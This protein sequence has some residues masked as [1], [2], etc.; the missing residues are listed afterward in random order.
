MNITQ[1]TWIPN[2]PLPML[3]PKCSAS[4]NIPP[5]HKQP[6]QIQRKKSQTKKAKH[7]ELTR[8]RLV[9]ES[10]AQRGGGTH[11]SVPHHIRICFS[12]NRVVA[13]VPGIVDYPKLAPH[14]VVGT[15]FDPGVS[16]FEALQTRR[17]ANPELPK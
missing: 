12:P 7:Q 2:S 9:P 15:M 8:R 4:I 11:R 14:A 17:F 3:I 1:P 5:S 6:T 10:T 13:I 16:R